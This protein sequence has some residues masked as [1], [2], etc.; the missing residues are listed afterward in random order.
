MLLFLPWLRGIAA[1]QQM[2]DSRCQPPHSA[3]SL[4]RPDFWWGFL[5][6]PSFIQSF[7]KRELI[8]KRF[9]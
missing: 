8:F 9:S 1:L 7:E 4:S 5:N 3:A 2:S 6:A